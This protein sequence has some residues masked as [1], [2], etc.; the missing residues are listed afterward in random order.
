MV[1]N[2]FHEVKRVTSKTG[3]LYLNVGDSYSGGKNWR[4]GTPRP[5]DGPR[6]TVAREFYPN[7]ID[8]SLPAKTLMAIP[9]RILIGMIDDGWI[10][11][12]KIIWYK[13][14]HTPSSVDDR[15]SNSYEFI[16]QFSKNNKPLY[17]RHLTSGEIIRKKPK[18]TR[19]EEG[20]DWQW[21]VQEI[22]DN[23]E[24]FEIWKLDQKPRSRK[25]IFKEGSK[26]FAR[27]KQ[28][29]WSGRDYYYDLD[30]IR[31]PWKKSTIDRVTGA[32]KNN[33]HFDP[34]R[35]KHLDA[36]PGRPR[37]Q[38]PYQVLAGIAKRA[39]VKWGDPDEEHK[40]SF[41]DAKAHMPRTTHEGGPAPQDVWG[42][43]RADLQVSLF[44]EEGKEY[45]GKYNQI[46]GKLKKQDN[47]P[48]PSSQTYHGFNARWKK[49]V[50]GLGMPKDGPGYSYGTGQSSESL[51]RT[52]GGV[53]HPSGMKN[54]GDVW[55]ITTR[56]HTFFHF[57]VFPLEL[58][59]RPMISS[60]PPMVCLSC[61]TPRIPWGPGY[62]KMSECNCGAGFRKAVTL[63]PFMGSGTVGLMSIMLGH[64]F[65]GI[66][67]SPKFI[68]IAWQ[69]INQ[70][71]AEA[72][73]LQS[74]LNERTAWQSAGGMD[75]FLS[76]T[77]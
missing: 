40:R 3:S 56:G 30:R 76:V 11:R 19:G 63:D 39:K 13:P 71:Q 35:H 32:I 2:V 33:E 15:P 64:K 50:E 29:L 45:S 5:R 70:L 43:P 54:P 59:Y 75:R 53:Y 31:E 41:A 58:V 57:A 21:T 51:H 42:I 6:S 27:F 67:L 7:H 26:W 34:K 12:A 65:I 28:T 47:V 52:P 61:G 66:D 44:P 17:W 9:E 36:M 4:N 49:T 77:I 46:L 38:S 74:V 73:R 68:E 10:C 25:E 22:A 20:L 72:L 1:H 60:C 55:R 23:E 14:N 62:S 37:S 48:G 8:K 18:G 24:E 69:R 16:Y